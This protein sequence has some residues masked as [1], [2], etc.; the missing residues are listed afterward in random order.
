MTGGVTQSRSCTRQTPSTAGYD[1]IA[2]TTL[3][4]LVDSPVARVS[5]ELANGA[6]LDAT[7]RDSMFVAW[8]PSSTAFTRASAQDAAGTVLGGDGSGQTAGFE[9]TF[10]DGP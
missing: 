10:E 2:L 8:R 9:T 7:V 3:V 4:G 6:Q 5:V 1:E